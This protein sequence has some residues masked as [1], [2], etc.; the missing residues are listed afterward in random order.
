M[1]TEDQGMLST[2]ELKRV[3]ELGFVQRLC[4]SLERTKKLAII[5]HGN[6]LDGFTAYW[7]AHRWAVLRALEDSYLYIDGIA[8][9]YQEEP[10]YSALRGRTILF[11]D[12]SY[13]YDVLR[14]MVEQGVE[15]IFLLDHHKSAYEDVRTAL[16]EN[17]L[18]E[19][20]VLPLFDMDRSGAG[21]T[22]DVLM[23]GERPRLIDL[24][25]DRDLWRFQYADT[26]A[27]NA[28]L[29]SYDYS[30][31]TWERLMHG[32]PAVDA[33]AEVGE[34]LQRKLEKDVAELARV[35]LQWLRIGGFMVPAVNV[36]YTHASEMGHLLLRQHPLADFAATYYDKHNQRVFSLR[37]ADDR[38]DVQAVAVGYGGGGHRNAAGFAVGFN[39]LLGSNYLN[40]EGSA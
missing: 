25:E 7:A 12:F 17:L 37:S 26:K 33:L 31:S 9:T 36:P 19:H 23:G 40:P 14:K 13:K 22:W 27:V 10:D 4:E 1:T 6:C 39:H 15:S 20:K 11:V 28:A 2:A 18:P 34:A 5:Y 29:F 38:T 8:G 35:Q 16:R 32:S 21:L 3:A 30:L 24:I